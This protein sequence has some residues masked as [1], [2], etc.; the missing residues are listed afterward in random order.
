MEQNNTQQKGQDSGKAVH[1]E[2]DMTDETPII[3]ITNVPFNDLT[4]DEVLDF[5]KNDEVEEVVA[6]IVTDYETIEIN[7][8]QDIDEIL[9][10]LDDDF[11]TDEFFKIYDKETFGFMETVNLVKNGDYLIYGDWDDFIDTFVESLGITTEHPA[12]NYLDFEK[13]QYD[14]ET[15]GNIYENY[16]GYIIET[17]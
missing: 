13:I 8:I 14:I 2:I 1:L 7:D 3:K 6:T 10:M 9:E 16:K 5:I 17:Y 4:T 12:Y 11:M 15:G